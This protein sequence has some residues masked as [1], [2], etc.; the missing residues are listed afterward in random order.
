MEA[1]YFFNLQNGNWQQQDGDTTKPGINPVS[2]TG[3]FGRSV[4]LAGNFAVIG[5]PYAPNGGAAAVYLVSPTS[6]T[7]KA[8]LTASEPQPDNE[9]LG[10]KD[11]SAQQWRRFP[12]ASWSAHQGGTAAWLCIRG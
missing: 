3:D 10:E 5:K 9:Q 2:G 7:Q 8:T 4:A 11:S 12:D 1:V 6:V